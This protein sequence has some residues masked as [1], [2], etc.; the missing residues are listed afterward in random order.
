M[1]SNPRDRLARLGLASL[2][3]FHD[4]VPRGYREFTALLTDGS[5]DLIAVYGRLGRVW[6]G[7]GREPF[8]TSL[9]LAR[10]AVDQARALGDSATTAE[11]LVM[12][13]F[14]GARLGSYGAALDTLA[15]A[16]RMVPANL[17]GLRGRVLCTASQMMS[18]A[19]R[20]TARAIGNRGLVLAHQAGDARVLGLCYHSLAAV[21]GTDTNDPS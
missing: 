5:K 2:A 17:P 4:D 21:S 18:L 20:P 12:I 19:G 1:A 13:G 11:A 15:A 10:V 7:F 6:N 16:E 8:D 3:R 14:L 9:A